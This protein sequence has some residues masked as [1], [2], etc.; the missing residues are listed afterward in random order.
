MVGGAWVLIDYFEFK[1]TNNELTNRQL[2]LALKTAELNQSSI[3]LNDQLNQLKLTRTVQGRLEVGGDS[4]IVRSAKFADG[5]FLYRLDIT[6][7]IKNIS[8]S[9]VSVPAVVTE[10]FIGRTP[11]AA[12]NSGQ[13]LHVNVPSS[14]LRTPTSGSVEWSR[15]ID[16]VQRVPDQIDEEIGKQIANFSL[17]AGGLIGEIRSGE[18]ANWTG[19]FVLKARSEDMAGAVATFWTQSED[20]PRGPYTYTYHEILSEA[21][22]AQS[23]KAQ[24]PLTDNQLNSPAAGR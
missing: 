15:V 11:V 2:E 9:N 4:S 17:T 12:L 3:K 16:F 5:T 14:W 6:L 10:V 7:T 24:A 19:T 21:G 23:L 8:D 22:D 1:K 13:A 20:G 18:R